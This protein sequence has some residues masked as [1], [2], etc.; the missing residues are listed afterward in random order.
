MPW[1]EARFSGEEPRPGAQ[2]PKGPPWKRSLGGLCSDDGKPAG[3]MPVGAA[4]RPGTWGWGGRVRSEVSACLEI[5]AP[6]T[7][8]GDSRNEAAQG[9][10]G[11][12]A[13][14]VPD[15]VWA[16]VTISRIR[17]GTDRAEPA[18]DALPRPCLCVR[19][20]SEVNVT[21]LCPKRGSSRREQSS[22]RVSRCHMEIQPHGRPGPLAQPVREGA[23][24]SRSRDAGGTH[25][26]ETHGGGRCNL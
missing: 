7:T 16:Q 15:S 19:S 11:A 18:W 6:A 2:G 26:W 9:A 13:G 24:S 21:Q 20:L 17:P 4:R 10:S 1:R 5:R 22:R 14:S 8:R 23:R 3:P 12:V 25:S